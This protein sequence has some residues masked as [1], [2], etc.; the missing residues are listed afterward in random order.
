MLFGYSN[1]MANGVTSIPYILA[2]FFFP[3]GGRLVD[4]LGRH[5]FWILGSTFAASCAHSLIMVSPG[6]VYFAPVIAVIIIGFA[7]TFCAA[8]LWPCVAL[9]AKEKEL[10]TAYGTMTSALNTGLSI[11]PFIVG[12]ITNNPDHPNYRYAEL[13]FV[14]CGLISFSVTVILIILD[15]RGLR[16]LTG[17][18]RAVLRSSIK[19]L[20]DIEE[21][22]E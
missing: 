4:K 10:G 14:I 16:R 11:A 17:K 13:F 18:P 12:L 19:E 22:A 2:V 1:L 8:A 15:R 20:K 3:I 9:L 7:Y 6:G 21:I 5:A